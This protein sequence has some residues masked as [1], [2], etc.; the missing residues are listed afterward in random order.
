MGGLCDKS[1]PLKGL[2]KL[3]QSV[4]GPKGIDGRRLDSREGC[5]HSDIFVAC[6][7]ES[8]GEMRQFRASHGPGCRRGVIP[9]GPETIFKI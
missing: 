8:K 9:S 5:T 6:P 4:T 2:K 7:L 3:S 1:L